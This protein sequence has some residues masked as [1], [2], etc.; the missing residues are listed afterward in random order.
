MPC[1]ASPWSTP[2][3][4]RSFAANTASGRSSG[5]RAAIASPVAA[6][7][8]RSLPGVGSGLER[9]A[10]RRR[11]RAPRTRLAVDDLADVE[12]SA[13]EQDAATAGLD[14]MLG[15]E[16]AAELVIHADRAELLVVAAA[17]DEH[18]R[19]PA[20]AQPAQPRTDL[21]VGRDQDAAHALLLEEVEV[22]GLALDVLVAVAEDH[23]Q[24][25]PWRPRSR[26]RGRGR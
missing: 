3:A 21:A 18:R 6:R 14:Q 10:R 8:R 13:R 26:R 22:A 2:I 19:G 11:P 5:A 23:R 24:A 7:R 15:R 16:P 20:L 9:H 25:V 17:V 12:R 1:R 4:T